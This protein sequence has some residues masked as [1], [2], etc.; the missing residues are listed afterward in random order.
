M[1]DALEP[2]T[3]DELAELLRAALRAGGGQISRMTS[4]AMATVIAEHL[5]DRL[6]LAGVMAVKAP[7]GLPLTD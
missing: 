2:L 6:H 1:F 4:V 7:Q 3:D 5:V